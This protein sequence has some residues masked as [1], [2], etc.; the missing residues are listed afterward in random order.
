MAFMAAA[1][2]ATSSLV[3]SWMRWCEVAAGHA[4]AAVDQDPHRLEDP[5]VEEPHQYDQGN[6]TQKRCDPGQDDPGSVLPAHMLAK[7]E[8]LVLQVSRQ[9]VGQLRQVLQL[10]V[11]SADVDGLE[12]PVAFVVDPSDGVQAVLNVADRMP[13][14]LLVTDV[15]GCRVAGLQGLLV[16]PERQP[17][18][19]QRHVEFQTHAGG[20]PR[21]GSV[22]RR[23]STC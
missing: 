2:S 14:A 15:R 13:L 20:K 1:S 9:F 22:E 10:V 21:V 23:S 12:H 5:D 7:D 6:A 11:Q 4:A 17:H 3:F 19:S 16:V 8:H 18:L